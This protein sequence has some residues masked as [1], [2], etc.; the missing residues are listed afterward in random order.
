MIPGAAIGGPTNSSFDPPPF[1]HDVAYFMFL[2]AALASI[3][4]LAVVFV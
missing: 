1:G 2:I 4:N 3:T